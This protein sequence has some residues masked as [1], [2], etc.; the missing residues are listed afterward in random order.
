MHNRYYSN[1][2]IYSDRIQ[3]Y[4]AKEEKFLKKQLEDDASHISFSAKGLS[5]LSD[6]YN[7]G[8]EFKRKFLSNETGKNKFHGSL[9]F[10]RTEVKVYG[11][12]T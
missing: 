3:G 8:K 6:P 11:H 9:W 2:C 12:K 7:E 10:W 5:Q 1:L 4:K